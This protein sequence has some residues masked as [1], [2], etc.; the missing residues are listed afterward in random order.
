M[1][2]NRMLR[3]LWPSI[4]LA[5]IACGSEPPTSPDG[6]A[7][8]KGTA[9]GG[10]KTSI[11]VTAADPDTVPIG[12][13]LAVRILGSGFGSDATVE[14]ALAGMTTT[15]VTATS[16]SFISSTELL[17]TTT[18][19]ADAPLSGYDIAVTSG[20]KRGIGVQ[21]LTVVAEEIVLPQPGGVRSSAS[22]V[23]D[24]GIIVGAMFD[25]ADNLYPLRWTPDGAGGWRAEIIGTAGRSAIAINNAGEILLRQHDGTTW[26][27]WVRRS[28][29]TEYSLGAWAYGLDIADDGTIIGMVGD[30]SAT[31]ST[32]GAWARSGPSS[33]GPFT[34][35]PLGGYVAPT[36]TMISASGEWI[37]G[38]V[39]KT[40]DPMEWAVVWRRV[41]GLWT[42]PILVDADP[43]AALAI[44]SQG[45]I[46]GAT[47]PCSDF[48]C[49]S[50]PVRWPGAG[51]SKEFLESDGSAVNGYGFVHGMNEA[52]DVVGR[53]YQRVSSKGRGSLQEV[54]ALWL[55]G[56]TRVI[57]LGRPA[58]AHAINN[59]GVVVGRN[60]S[61]PHHRAIAWRVP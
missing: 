43:G 41:G 42:G 2:R 58:E 14:Y 40:A 38:R 44:N 39:G 17:T 33:W 50:L 10:P 23:N 55:R 30:G 35:L 5:A 18:V 53:G 12:T 45:K 49:T 37:A 32:W 19:A 6:P 57:S 56:T 59:R 29:G 46:A 22:D 48:T 21:Q 61:W 47:W 25:A 13:T 60:D 52:G 3:A 9:G 11:T 15:K 20:G 4:A 26:W 54:P 51:G 28:D 8:A 36:L 7:L 31:P 34:P 24:D 27:S 16:V 1:K